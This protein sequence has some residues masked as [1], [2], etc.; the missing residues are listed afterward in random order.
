ME[1]EDGSIVLLTS[2]YRMGKRTNRRELSV[3]RGSSSSV[4]FSLV[5]T[6]SLVFLFMLNL[7]SSAATFL[8][9]VSGKE[10]IAADIFFPFYALRV[11]VT[12]DQEGFGGEGMQEGSVQCRRLRVE[13]RMYVCMCR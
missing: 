3:N 11:V 4:L 1:V 12:R 2:W 6:T 13:K 8:E 10:A 5:A 9:G 7:A